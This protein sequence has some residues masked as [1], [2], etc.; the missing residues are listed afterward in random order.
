MACPSEPQGRPLVRPPA[1]GAVAPSLGG[2]LTT[3]SPQGQSWGSWRCLVLAIGLAVAVAV[4]VIAIAIIGEAFKKPFKLDASE[5]I[6]SAGGYRLISDL[7]SS[8]VAL[9]VG[10]AFPAGALARILGP[11]RALAGAVSTRYLRCILG[12]RVEYLKL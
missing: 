10:L 9:A 7:T 2:C 6:G 12:T 3:P 5:P 11:P 1:W 8:F 4:N